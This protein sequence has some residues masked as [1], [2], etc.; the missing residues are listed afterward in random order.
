MRY[1]SKFR[2]T[3]VAALS[4]AGLSLGSAANAAIVELDVTGSW[5]A[6][7]YDVSSTGPDFPVGRPTGRR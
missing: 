4:L 2:N 1:P 7:D 3:F 5:L 6:A